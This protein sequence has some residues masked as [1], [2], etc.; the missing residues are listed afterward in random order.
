V[1]AENLAHF[2]PSLLIRW[3]LDTH[4]TIDSEHQAR[5]HFAPLTSTDGG[6]APDRAEMLALLPVAFP[7]GT[8]GAGEPS[9]MNISPVCHRA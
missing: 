1:G 2:F 8:S 4:D 6:P 7:T 3:H 5:E 9:H